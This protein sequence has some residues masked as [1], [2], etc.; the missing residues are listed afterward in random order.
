MNEFTLQKLEFDKIKNMLL[1]ECSSSLGQEKVKNL[2]PVSDYERIL[3]WQQETTEGV[4]VRR[5]EPQ[6]PLGGI[7]DISSQIKRAEV[8][9]ILEPEDFLKILDTLTASCKLATFLGKRKKQYSSPRLEWWAEQLNVLENLERRSKGLFLQKGDKE[10]CFPKLANVR[11]KIIT[12]QNRI[13][14]KLDNLVKSDHYQKYLQDSIVTIRGDR[15]VVPVKQEYRNQVPGIIH[16]QSAS[17]ATLFIEPMAVVEL[18]NDLRKAYSEERDEILEILRELSEKIGAYVDELRENL[19]VLAHIDF[20]FAKARLSEKLNAVAP[21]IYQDQMIKIIKGRHPLIPANEVVPMT[22]EMGFDYDALV[23]TGPNTGGKTVTLKTVGLFV[24]MSQSGLHIP[25]EQGSG[26]GIFTKVFADIG[27]EQSIEQS[28]STFSS[29]MTNIVNILSAIDQTSLILL[30]ELGAGTDPSEG[31]ALA[32]SILDYILQKGAKIIATTHYSELK[33]Y[34]FRTKRVQNASVE[35]DLKTL[36]PT[37]RLLIGIPGKSNAFEIATRLGLKEEIVEKARSLISKEEQNVSDLIQSLEMNRLTAEIK[38]KEVEE[39][40][41]KVNIKL[42]NIEEQEAKMAA[43]AEKLKRKAEEEAL[44]IIKNARRESEQIL[45]DLRAL[46]K[47]EILKAEEKARLY[48]NQLEEKEEQLAQK[49]L[50]G[51]KVTGRKPKDLKI[52]QEVFV[53]KLNQKAI[54][55]TLPNS[56]G[57]VQVQ[58]GIIKINVNLEELQEIDKK[59]SRITTGSGKIMAEKQNLLKRAGFS[60]NGSR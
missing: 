18:N 30:D 26:I 22:L 2:K 23:I 9:G 14:E 56:N 59:E 39:K 8:G 1:K 33:T 47:E 32:I 43:I 4:T 31:A 46:A 12:L 17:G 42:A 53:P 55:L 27:D 11:K 45:K 34:A 16:D 29:H 3:L 21:Q 25:A 10:Q 51:P 24:L 35:F 5:Y 57:E 36:K 20:I 44:E 52:G 28:L 48:K 37:Y 15:Y 19:E 50:E 41:E 6:V 38:R 60:W 54:V 58:A 40:L 13:K 49:V 7:K